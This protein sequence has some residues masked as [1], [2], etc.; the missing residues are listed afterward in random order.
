MIR[1][2]QVSKRYPN[3]HM[4]LHNLSFH[5]KVGE[6]VFIAGHSGAGK[7]T[8][9]KLIMCME[10]PSSGQVHVGGQNLRELSGDDIPHLRRQVGVVFQNHQLLFDR[11]VFDNVA[12]PLIIN[13]TAPGEVGRR[14]RAALDK[15]GLLSK[16]NL[17]P[18][19]LSGGEQQRVGVARAVVHKPALLLADE[20]TG[21]LDPA[22]SA[23]IMSLFEDFNRVGVTVIIA[24][25]DLPLI[26]TLDHRMLTLDQGR[27]LR[28]GE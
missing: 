10:R 26:A 25:H 22:L 20:P 4:G 23:E 24:S 19:A 13:G 17:C 2:E 27:L 14:V 16:E 21:N 8:L 1:F 3:G 12:L 5:I 28:D 11:T 6:M 15:V 18:I 9:L 7:S